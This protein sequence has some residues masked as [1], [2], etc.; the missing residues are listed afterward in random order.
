MI[1]RVKRSTT[2][3]NEFIANKPFVVILTI[4]ESAN[5]DNSLMLRNV[6][7]HGKITE[8]PQNQK[9]QHDEL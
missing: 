1:A 4:K 9:V 8:P 6:L 5:E 7:F 2:F 3:S